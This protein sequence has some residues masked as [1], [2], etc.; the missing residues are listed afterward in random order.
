MD[1]LMD[2]VLTKAARTYEGSE[3]DRYRCK[4]GH[5]FGMDFRK[6]PAT[7]PMWP[8]SQEMADFAKQQQ[9]SQ[10]HTM[11]RSGQLPSYALTM[12]RCSLAIVLGVPAIHLVIRT[13]T[14]REGS[15]HHAVFLLALGAAEAIAAAFLLFPRFQRP[16]AWALAAILLIASGFHALGG[17]MPPLPFLV[18]WAA[19]A[20]IVTSSQADR[21]GKASSP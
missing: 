20:V 16:A 19:I 7:E 17:E 1:C 18:Y 21:E 14:G 12:L 2:G 15:G 5:E 8:P 6:G 4:K 9:Q 13:A 11:P 3:D 10:E